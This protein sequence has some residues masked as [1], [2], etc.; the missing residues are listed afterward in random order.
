MCNSRS[1]QTHFPYWKFSNSSMQREA[2]LVLLI[3]G[4]LK[5]PEKTVDT[6]KAEASLYLF[7]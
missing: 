4:E 2:C 6:D 3:S 5:N 1:I 7:K